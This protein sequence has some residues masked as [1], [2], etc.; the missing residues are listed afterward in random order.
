MIA[1]KFSVLLVL[2]ALAIQ[3]SC[4][5][6]TSQNPPK[7]E[8][9]GDP[10]AIAIEELTGTLV[11][12]AMVSQDRKGFD[13]PISAG[14]FFIDG[15]LIG[16]LP[17]RKELLLSPRESEIRVVLVDEHDGFSYGFSTWSGRLSVQRGKR[18]V[19]DISKWTLR[20][21]PAE[22][23]FHG[24]FRPA[25]DYVS[26]MEPT[27][28]VWGFWGNR[29]ISE[30]F[31]SSFR[32]RL[33]LEWQT[34]E[35]SPE[36][37]PIGIVLEQLQRVGQPS[38]RRIWVELPEHLGGPR[39]LDADQL[40]AVGNWLKWQWIDKVRGLAFDVQRESSQDREF[41]FE[42]AVAQMEPFDRFVDERAVMIKDVIRE[43]T[44]AVERAPN[45]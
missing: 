25:E 26:T 43:L 8:A 1:M 10:K 20:S 39:E 16:S 32:N 29:R 34:F 3:I 6:D 12:D 9:A 41:R 23:Q 19:L 18:T 44:S 11:I 40:R 7:S 21:H 17:F 27:V 24:A 35:R 45:E 13:D 14:W 2:G 33:P 30:S 42:E 31:I 5:G 4:R 37:K 15:Q 22:S 28:G 36:W 38:R